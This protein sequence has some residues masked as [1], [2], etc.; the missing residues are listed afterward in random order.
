MNLNSD[1]RNL[2][3]ILPFGSEIS[4]SNPQHNGR[5][6]KRRL[7]PWY[8]RR[9]GRN[10]IVNACRNTVLSHPVC[11]LEALVT[12]YNPQCLHYRIQ[13][14]ARKKTDFSENR[15]H[16]GK[17]SHVDRELKVIKL[18]KKDCNCRCQSIA[19]L[20]LRKLTYNL[21]LSLAVNLVSS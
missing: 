17:K 1:S 12:A 16:G 9:R 18:K 10:P 6:L 14:S 13:Y 11:L 5:N 7:A 2:Q 19:D 21:F 15:A 3:S 20:D 8:E 4:T